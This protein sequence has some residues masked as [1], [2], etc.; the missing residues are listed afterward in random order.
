VS[1]PVISPHPDAAE[2]VSGPDALKE[3]RNDW[4]RLLERSKACTIFLTWEWIDAWW[5]VYGG[6]NSL[7]IIVVRDD[8]GSIRGIA[9]FYRQKIRLF[10]IAHAYAVRFIGMGGDV[11]PDYLDIFSDAGWEDAVCTSVLQKLAGLRHMWD[12][13]DLEDI[14]ESSS[15]VA[16]LAREADRLGWRFN[17]RHHTTCP[18]IMLAPAWEEFLAGKSRN[19]RKKLK[20]HRRVFER[21]F[22]AAFCRVEQPDELPERMEA[23]RHMHHDRWNGMSGSF[24]SARYMSFHNAVASHFLAKGWLR[25]YFLKAD[26]RDVAALYCFSFAGVT[27]Y[28]QSGR[29]SEF[30]KYHAG[31]VI[32]G[33]AVEAAVREGSTEFDFLCGTEEYKFRWTD[34]ARDNLRVTVRP[35]AAGTNMLEAQLWLSRALRNAAKRLLPSSLAW[36]L[37]GMARSRNVD[38]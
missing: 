27:S 16:L 23:L 12:T 15:T 36:Y 28:Y 38:R 19:F 8:S 37:R 6:E 34:E 11:A 10:G 29:L 25:L 9:P 1:S 5:R 7:F 17:E 33:Y 20:E 24:Q 3:L 21:D 13:L 22:N 30:E 2:V 35:R 4:N 14:P 26:G 32:I 18:Y 31:S